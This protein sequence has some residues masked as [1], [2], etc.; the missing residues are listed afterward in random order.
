MAKRNETVNAPK[1]EQTTTTRQQ[2]L[3]AEKADKAAGAEE[4]TETKTTK[5]SKASKVEKDEGGLARKRAEFKHTDSGYAVESV[6]G[7]KP[8]VRQDFQKLEGIVDKI[9]ELQEN[10]FEVSVE[11]PQG[12]KNVK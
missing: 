2:G 8:A 5:A 6:D 7:D 11:G 10:G 9:R 12:F 3:E 1:E 4:Q